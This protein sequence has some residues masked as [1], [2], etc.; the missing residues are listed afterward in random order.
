MRI[1]QVHNQYR[2]PGGEDRVVQAEFD[3]LQSAGH[4]VVS[5][6]VTNPSSALR[7]AGLLVLSPGNPGAGQ[8]V[9]RLAAQFRP[10]VAHVHNTWFSLSPSVLGALQ[11][12]GVPVV[13]TLHNYR[14]MCV[15]SLLFRDGHPCEE[16]VGSHPWHG[17]RHRCYRDS[18]LASAAA[19]GAISINRSRSVWS[20]NV[21]R[22]LVLSQFSQQ[23]FAAAGIPEERM[24]RV[25]NFVDD[26]GPRPA[27]P[28]QSNSVLFV[29]RLSAE[30]GADLLLRAW[31]AASGLELVVVGDGP[32]RPDL[33]RVGGS[34]VRFLGRRS[35]PEVRNLMLHSRA[36]VFPSLAYENQ[37]IVLL[38]ALSAGLPVVASEGGAIPEVFAGSPHVQLV[39]AGD[40]QAW[41]AALGELSQDR[42]VTAAGA[43]M[44][45][46]YEE[47][48]TPDS[49]RSTLEAA[50]RDAIQSRRR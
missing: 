36:L 17:V 8:A 43:S 22:F 28:D 11:R 34:S 46:L 25:S 33:E 9:K 15:N 14:L 19:A 18:A 39:A 35:A 21:D 20:R 23:R 47:R 26:P 3:L 48:Y 49:T 16:C 29:G 41:T 38:E 32:Q 31:P 44:R 10:D 5:H 2:E 6:R 40:R 27:P 42:F 13:M 24:T 30:K 37:P 7:S 50:Y 12:S 1:L 45:T 4:E